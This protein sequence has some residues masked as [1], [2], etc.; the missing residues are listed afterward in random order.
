MQ[1]AG[2]VE[3]VR[4]EVRQGMRIGHMETHGIPYLWRQVR[5]PWNMLSW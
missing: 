4:G 2:Q 5:Q 3:G 1:R